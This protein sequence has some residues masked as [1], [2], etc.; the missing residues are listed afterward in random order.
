VAILNR[1]K[2]D[3]SEETPE[4]KKLRLGGIL[5]VAG[6][7][8]GALAPV[9]PGLAPVAQVIGGVQQIAGALKK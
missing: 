4:E 9:V 7:I 1:S 5:N 2:M 6:K 3:F 8:T